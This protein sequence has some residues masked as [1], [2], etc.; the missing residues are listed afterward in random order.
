MVVCHQVELGVPRVQHL[1][2]V[3]RVVA[4]TSEHP[5]AVV[6]P[7]QVLVVGT[8]H[9]SAHPVVVASMVVEH[10]E[11]PTSERPAAVVASM[12]VV[13]STAVEH[14]EHPTS[15]RPA[16]PSHHLLAPQ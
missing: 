15:E 6:A 3:R 1:V 16:V 5:V 9:P 12:V 4:S 2:A 13:A 11:H 7:I 10:R 8:Q 14:R